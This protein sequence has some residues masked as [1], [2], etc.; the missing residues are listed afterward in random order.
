MKSIVRVA[1][2]ST[3]GFALPALAASTTVNVSLT[4]AG[5]EATPAANLGMP[6]TGDPNMAVMHVTADKAEVPA[7]QVT[8]AVTNK[9][10]DF[11]HEMLVVKVASTTKPL[12]Y[13][14]AESRVDEEAAG[15]LGEVSELRSRR[16]GQPDPDARQGHLHAV[17]QCARPLRRRHVD[18]GD[19]D[20]THQ[21]DA[22][23]PKVANCLRPGR[24]AQPCKGSPLFS[25]GL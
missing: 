15:D 25:P 8:F 21:P 2:L 22:A 13:V 24:G 5:G 23:T 11:V 1:A 12:P 19:R 14:E 7:G 4:D 17:L 3:A 16:L 10:K 6:M 20:L 18:P 9:S